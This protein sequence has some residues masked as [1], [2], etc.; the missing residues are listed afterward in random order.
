MAAERRQPPRKGNSELSKKPTPFAPFNPFSLFFFFL[1]LPRVPL[2]AYALISLSFS[3]GD[4]ATA[5][6][7][8]RSD[9]GRREA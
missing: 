9:Q 2:A 3:C 7:T 4:F 1:P 5:W 6:H 8:P